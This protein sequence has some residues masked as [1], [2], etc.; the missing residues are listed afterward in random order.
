MK[1]KLRVVLSALFFSLLISHVALAGI[2]AV[3]G[4][5]HEK[6]AKVG[7]SYQGVII[8]RNSDE[9]P[10][11]AKIYQTDYLFSFDGRNYY[12]EPGKLPRSNANWITFSPS[13]LVIPPK[14]QSEV[15][16]AVK[17]PDN[18]TLVGTYWS[19]LMIENIGKDSPEAEVGKSNDVEARLG[20]RTVIRYGIQMITHIGDTGTRKLKFLNTKLMKEDEKRILQV[21][22]ENIGERRLKSLLWAEFYDEEGNYAGRFEGGRLNLYPGTSVRYKVDLSE[23]QLLFS[24]EGHGTLPAPVSKFQTDLNNGNIPEG[25]LKEFRNNGIL[26]SQNATISIEEAGTGW[27]IYDGEKNYT[28]RGEEDRLNIYEA[29]KALRGKYKALVVADCGG[30]DIFGATYSLKFGE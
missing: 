26:L 13:R 15:N 10:Q 24:I 20:I 3:G 28:V 2:V 11:E 5:T 21:D 16:Y 18:G 9:E 4:L 17:V 27:L 1:L 6:V 30:D 8:L 12:G 14:G 7:E 23:P 29:P 25:L 19:V 22:I